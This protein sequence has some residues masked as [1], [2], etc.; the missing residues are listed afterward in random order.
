[1]SKGTVARNGYIAMK[2]PINA[3]LQVASGVN[4]GSTDSR[5]N[6][7]MMMTSSNKFDA[8]ATDKLKKNSRKLNSGIPAKILIGRA[9]NG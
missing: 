5:K 3:S 2:D 8:P 9:N 4:E 7:M 1:V 6:Q